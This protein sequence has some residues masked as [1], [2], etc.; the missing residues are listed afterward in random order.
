VINMSN[1]K[2]KMRPVTA[3]NRRAYNKAIDAAE[4]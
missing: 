2:V 4:A 3:G 1:N